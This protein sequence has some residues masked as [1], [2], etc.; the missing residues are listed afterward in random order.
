MG[1][2][3]NG[4][5]TYTR[6]IT[7]RHDSTALGGLHTAAQR[8]FLETL[9]ESHPLGGVLDASDADGCGALV[10]VGEEEV[11]IMGIELDLVW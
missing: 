5:C 1:H 4:R 8:G 2:N 6:V 7:R 10:A 3:A 9:L 11:L